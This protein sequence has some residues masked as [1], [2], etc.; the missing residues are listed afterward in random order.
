MD[1]DTFFAYSDTKAASAPRLFPAQ[2]LDIHD[3]P[4]SIVTASE[5]YRL[6]VIT[7]ASMQD[8]PFID[9]LL[10]S[11]KSCL[12]TFDQDT[13]WLILSPGSKDHLQQQHSEEEV[14]TWIHSPALA[15]H[16]DLYVT[17]EHYQGH[18][19]LEVHPTRRWQLIYHFS[20]SLPTNNLEWLG[21]SLSATRV[22]WEHRSKTL[23]QS[24]QKKDKQISSASRRKVPWQPITWGWHAC[25]VE[26]QWV[27]L[28]YMPVQ[29]VI[30]CAKA[31][32][33]LELVVRPWLV[34]RLH[35]HLTPLQH[36][37]T[38][39]FK[40]LQYHER[41]LSELFFQLG[42]FLSS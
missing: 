26:I 8:G 38:L 16:L 13:R 4:Y 41:R 3:R 31:S 22:E 6:F 20:P 17:P 37:S 11:V 7:L 19:L 23:V 25:P 42:S 21:H 32:A 27:I 30:R 9:A 24:V 14:V 10:S 28:E 36:G 35:T 29:D 18:F 39:P 12:K 5:K 15:K 34:A 33:A 1:I 40:I 2:I